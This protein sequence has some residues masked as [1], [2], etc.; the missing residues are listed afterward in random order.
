MVQPSLA[1]PAGPS[2]LGNS[3]TAAESEA[4]DG[5]DDSSEDDDDEDEDEDGD[6]DEDGDVSMGTPG[7]ALTPRQKQKATEKITK[8]AQ[9]SARKVCRA[10][11]S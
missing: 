4:E 11:R 8:A 3:F 5:E 1:P 9:R 2:K 6:G 7:K 10:C